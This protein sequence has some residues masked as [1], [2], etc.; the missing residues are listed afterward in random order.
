MIISKVSPGNNNKKKEIKF[1]S[2]LKGSMLNEVWVSLQ[3]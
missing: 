1:E 2:K 3:I